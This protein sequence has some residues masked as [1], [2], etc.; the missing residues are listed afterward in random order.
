MINHYAESA[1]KQIIPEEARD[2]GSAR[3]TLLKVADLVDDRVLYFRDCFGPDEVA[4]FACGL[5]SF[6]VPA[7]PD[8]DSLP[9]LT[10][11]ADTGEQAT[12]VEMNPSPAYWDPLRE[13]VM[14]Q[15]RPSM[16]P[17]MTRVVTPPS[18]LMVP[19]MHRWASPPPGVIPRVVTPPPQH[20]VV[21]PYSSASSSTSEYSRSS[22]ASTRRRPTRRR[23]RHS[24]IRRRRRANR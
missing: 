2:F 21:M 19:T 24:R 18:P 12:E 16:V 5:F 8:V 13:R 9:V 23:R 15:P 14:I 1:T 6:W 10:S 20:H 22:S 4:A 17:P 7:A 3:D 11:E